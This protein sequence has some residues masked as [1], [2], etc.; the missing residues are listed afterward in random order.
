[1][2]NVDGTGKMRL[3]NN[4]ERDSAPRWMPDGKRII[5]FSSNENKNGFIVNADLSEKRNLSSDF[6]GIS[7]CP[8][9]DDKMVAM[10]R[11][12]DPKW[13]QE[14]EYLRRTQI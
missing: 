3:I 14:I 2:M 8:S 9:P 4:P 1:M 7:P 11:Q 12:S 13:M 10:E 5:Y 6:L